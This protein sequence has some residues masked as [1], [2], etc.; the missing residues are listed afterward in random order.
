MN[1]DL[2]ASTSWVLG[3]Q[4][5]TTTKMVAFA[6]ISAE[7]AMTYPGKETVATKTVATELMVLFT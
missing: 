2:P 4:A 6:H 5:C 7:K 1:L 3:L